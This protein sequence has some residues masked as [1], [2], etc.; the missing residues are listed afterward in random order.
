LT[1]PAILL[2]ER[3][4]SDLHDLALYPDAGPVERGLYHITRPIYRA[5]SKLSFGPPAITT[6]EEGNKEATNQ[7]R[8]DQTQTDADDKGVSENTTT[9]NQHMAE[10]NGNELD[11]EAQ[12]HIKSLAATDGPEQGKL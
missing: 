8:E 4:Q 12:R 10:K 6:N 3:L 9:D 11:L 1:R 7:N 2:T 5:L